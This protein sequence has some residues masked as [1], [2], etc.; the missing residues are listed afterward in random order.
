LFRDVTVP[1]VQ[2]HILLGLPSRAEA[3]EEE[4]VLVTRAGGTIVGLVVDRLREGIDVVFKPLN[5]ILAGVRGYSGSA[6]LGDGRVLLVLNLKE[7]L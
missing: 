5:G 6:L 2:L 3:V 7:L 1:L 4:A